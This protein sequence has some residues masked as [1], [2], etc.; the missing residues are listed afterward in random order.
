MHLDS[1]V[2]S[3]SVAFPLGHCFTA[4]KFLVVGVLVWNSQGAVLVTDPT[5]NCISLSS[6]TDV[7]IFLAPFRST[8]S[9][10]IVKSFNLQLIPREL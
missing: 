1:V 3:A 5:I 8:N 4:S 7:F 9:H 6:P 2:V 10:G